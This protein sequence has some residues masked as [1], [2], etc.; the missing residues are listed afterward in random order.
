MKKIIIGCIAAT[1]AISAGGAG[2]VSAGSIN[3]ESICGIY[4]GGAGGLKGYTGN[5]RSAAHECLAGAAA[6]TRLPPI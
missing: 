5:P 6:T 4:A 2:S 3:A 1:I